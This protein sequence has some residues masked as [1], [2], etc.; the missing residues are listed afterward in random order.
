LP[1][2]PAVDFLGDA[3]DRQRRT[4]RYN[5]AIATGLLLL[6]AAIFAATGLLHERGVALSLIHAGSEAALVGGLA[7]WFAVTAL[8][9]YPLGLPI[10]RTAII[11]KNKDRIGEGLGQFVERNFLAPAVIADKLRALTPGRRLAAWLAAPA[12]ASLVADRL[13]EALPPIIRSLQ[14]H[15]LRD[16]VAR[17]FREQLRDADL[18]PLVG[19]SLALLTAGEQYDALFDRAIDAAYETLN[20]NVDRLHAVVTERSQW[21]VPKAIDRH[22]AEKIIGAIEELLGELRTPGSEGRQKFRAA[23]QGM[24]EQLVQSPAWRQRFNEM[25]D[26]LLDHPEVQA[27]LGAVWDQLR[28]LVLDDL[29]APRSRTRQ[30]LDTA[31]LSLGRT[32]AADPAMQQ[33]IDA[34]IEHMA[35]AVV[36]WRGEIARLIAE[37][38][39]G[40]DARTVSQRLELAIGS[41]LQYIRMNGTLVG[42]IAGC[43]LYLISHF[44]F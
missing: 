24:A 16:F 36:P 3:E 1:Q 41:D 7:D 5:R 35:L 26:R 14:D 6:A 13:V 39:H 37:V 17:S 22:V 12:N 9:R 21:W 8:F 20:A 10:P 38:V 25:K 23:V 42:A 32:L 29:A 34:G 2:E 43:V 4:L 40:W 15:E 28:A 11:P 27:W 44:A 19:R 33:R 31:F 30:A 18:A